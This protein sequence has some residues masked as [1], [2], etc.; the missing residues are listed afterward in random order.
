[1]HNYQ[2]RRSRVDT[3][4]SLATADE[5][6]STFF[7]YKR[8]ETLTRWLASGQGGGRRG[9]QGMI[10]RRVGMDMKFIVISS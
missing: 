10:E 6:P 5:S 7:F 1:M 9:A 8:E 3:L 2:N 4:A